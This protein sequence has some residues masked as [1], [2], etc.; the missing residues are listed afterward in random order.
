M[1]GARRALDIA[2]VRECVPQDH[3]AQA[4]WH[5][6]LAQNRGT[7]QPQRAR[8]A[9]WSWHALLSFHFQRSGPIGVGGCARVGH[10]PRALPPD[11]GCLVLCHTVAAAGCGSVYCLGCKRSPLLAR[12]RLTRVDEWA[13]RRLSATYHRWCW[14]VRT[15]VASGCT[16]R[17]GWALLGGKANDAIAIP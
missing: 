17:M 5:L 2:F 7:R 15:A 9:A 10:T 4:A 14:G 11:G 1:L 6:T 16:H 13:R 3:P 8:S 12:A